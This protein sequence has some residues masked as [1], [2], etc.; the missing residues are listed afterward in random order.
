MMNDKDRP[1]R[2]VPERQ[3]VT[4][5]SMRPRTELVRLVRLPDGTVMLDPDQRH[6]GRGAYA[7]KTPTCIE[8]AAKSSFARALR[9]RVP[10]ELIEDVLALG[11]PKPQSD[12]SKAP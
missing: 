7:C 3:C 12:S 9:Q 6:H 11:A 4:C 2:R 1:T 5:R 8:Q 10:K